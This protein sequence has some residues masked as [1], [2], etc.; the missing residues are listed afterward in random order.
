MF[1]LCCMFVTTW[2]IS[3]L[4]VSCSNHSP[5][6]HTSVAGLKFLHVISPLLRYRN[7]SSHV[8]SKFFDGDQ[9]RFDA[10]TKIRVNESVSGQHQ[11]RPVARDE[12]ARLP[13]KR[14][15]HLR[16]PPADAP[17]GRRTWKAWEEFVEMSEYDVLD[18]F[19]VR[20]QIFQT[21]GNAS[22]DENG[23]FWISR[24]WKV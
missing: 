14:L 13:W 19:N 11:Q 16:V 12:G 24:I 22:V 18:F 17:R 7:R 2:L 20:L 4:R 1:V 5:L 10:T 21:K 9:G 15:V 8:F 23:S 6:F 3:T